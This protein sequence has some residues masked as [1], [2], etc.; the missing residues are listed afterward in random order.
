GEVKNLCVWVEDNAGMGSLY[1][2]QHELVFVFK[3]GRADHRNNVHLGRFGR[4]RSNIW[5]YPGSNSFGRSKEEGNPS[6]LHPTVKPE[7]MVADATLDCSARGTGPRSLSG[8][9][10]DR[11]ACSRWSCIRTE[12]R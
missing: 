4:N 10:E 1:R 3:H 6:A 9:A 11:R 2:S 5:R 12:T 7:A 8:Y